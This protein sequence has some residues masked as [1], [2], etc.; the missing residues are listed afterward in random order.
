MRAKTATARGAHD[1]ET[2]LLAIARKLSPRRRAAL[3]EY[4]QFLAGRDPVPRPGRAQPLPRPRE[5][6]VVHA[7]KRLMK[8]YP[9]VD[10]STLLDATSRCLASHMVDGQAASAVI[11][12]LEALF[13]SAARRR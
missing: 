8:S 1:D 9:H 4:A 6:S 12:E 13:A 11:D 7:I 5:E 10:R 3:V 2:Q